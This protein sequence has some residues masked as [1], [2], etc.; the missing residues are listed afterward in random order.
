MLILGAIAEIERETCLQ[1]R[2]RCTGDR[3]EFNGEGNGCSTT[4][5]RRGGR[6]VIHLPETSAGTCRTHRI[7]L[8]EIG[9]ALGMWHEQSRP[10]RNQYVEILYQNVRPG[11]APQFEAKRSSETN[12]H[13]EPYDYAS[14]MHYRLDAFSRNGAPTIR[15]LTTATANST[16]INQG[17]PNIGR[18]GHLSTSDISQLNQMYSC[19][20]HVLTGRL[21]IYARYGSGLPDRDGWFAGDSDPYVRVIAYNHNGYSVSLRTHTDRGDESP[22]WYQWLDFGVNTWRS[23]TVQVFDDD[24]GSDDTLSDISTQSFAQ[25]VSRT[26][27]RKNCHSGYIYYDYFFS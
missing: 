18:E 8:H 17:R 10:D 3:I 7:V 22:E 1:F 15:R 26:Y 21:R 2:F 25:H 13:G 23:F 24:F 6:Q 12:N 16:Y 20:G 14:V 4:L 27:Q 11:L 5:G 19:P 9:H